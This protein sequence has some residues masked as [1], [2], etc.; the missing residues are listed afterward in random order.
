MPCTQR[1]VVNPG[2]TVRFKVTNAQNLLTVTGSLSDVRLASG[3]SQMKTFTEAQL[4]SGIQWNLVSQHVYV[5]MLTAIPQ[6]ATKDT[7]VTQEL[8]IGSGN[9]QQVTCKRRRTGVISTWDLTVR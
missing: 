7:S 8:T 2:Q 1:F 6:D 4:R 3:S 5:L 9:A